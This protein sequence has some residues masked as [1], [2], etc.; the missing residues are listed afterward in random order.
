[1]FALIF[2]S[3]LSCSSFSGFSSPS[4]PISFFPCKRFQS[5]PLLLPLQREQDGLLALP[6]TTCGLTPTLKMRL[7]R[8]LGL[9]QSPRGSPAVGSV[10]FQQ[11]VGVRGFVISSSAASDHR[12]L[13]WLLRLFSP[14]ATIS[15][16]SASFWR[17][18]FSNFPDIILPL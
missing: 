9:G 6:S 10:V 7:H 2:R 5:R 11:A 3:L 15:H 14:S 13:L 8:G 16:V 17:G 1:M 4:S 18:F 12:V